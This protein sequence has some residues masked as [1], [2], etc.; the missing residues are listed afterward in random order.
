MITP[1]AHARRAFEFAR[2]IPPQKLLRRIELILRRRLHDRLPRTGRF[3]G[4]L[5]ARAIAP[6]LPVFAPRTKLAPV[7]VS[8]DGNRSWT[9]TFLNRAVSMRGP[10]IDW[11]APGPGA[12]HQLWRMNLHYM[13]YLEGVDDTTWLSVVSDWIDANPAAA[14][15]AWRD[16]WNSYALSIRIVV[17]LQELARRADRLDEAATGRITASLVEQVRFLAENLETDLGGNHLVKNIKALVWAS[18]A[19]DGAE[20]LRWRQI[21]LGLLERQLGTQI[22]SDGVHDERS[23]S[24]HCQVMA[25]LLEIR[26]A[27]GHDPFDGRLDRTLAAMAQATADLAHPDGFVAQFNDAGLTMAYAPAEC[28]SVYAMM[29]GQRPQPR[30][31][32][33]FPTA[34]YFGARTSESYFVA[35]CG[36]IAPDD[37]PAH[38]HGD[39]LSFE[40]S[41]SGARF[42]VDQGVFEYIAGSRRDRSR[43]AASHNTL[44][45]DDAD[46]AEFFGAFRCGRRPGVTVHAFEPRP[47][48]FVL[49]GSHDGFS[50]LPGRPRHVRRFD[51]KTSAIT[52][53]DRLEGA[54]SLTARIGFL[55]HPEVATNR[56]TAG[57]AVRLSRGNSTATFSSTLPLAV[58]PAVWWPDMGHEF[59]TH[60]LVCALP[61]GTREAVT[62]ITIESCGPPAPAQSAVP[63]LEQSH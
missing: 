29:F 30:T 60:R 34:G 17:W 47:G 42:I 7:H 14:R 50:R 59:A 39:V 54:C 19:F 44:C 1:V 62:R 53:I 3:H 18:A 20:P 35:D 10:A 55:L 43:G 8:V 25:D 63:I 27:L 28:L 46:Q 24:Y 2:H 58:E 38:G 52:I 23:P 41:L 37:L 22:L 49:E 56:T 61:P 13:E 16:A 45:F 31:V 15:G 51:V 11:S 12:A 33:A 57:S 48:G 21:G 26:H 4:P 5:P 9:F 6:P 40:W 32:F 36:R